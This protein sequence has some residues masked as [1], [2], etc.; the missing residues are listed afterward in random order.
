[1]NTTVVLF[2]GSTFINSWKS[3]CQFMQVFSVGVVKKFNSFFKAHSEHMIQ[4]SVFKALSSK[5]HTATDVQLRNSKRQTQNP[6]DGCRRRTPQ[7][8]GNLRKGNLRKGNLRKGNN[9][10]LRL[11]SRV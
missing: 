2:S 1:M 9:I 10:Q 6:N 4:S 8:K 5:A 11:E 3:F 7:R